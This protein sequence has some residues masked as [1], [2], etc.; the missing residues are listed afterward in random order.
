MA[1]A[2][3]REW[4]FVLAATLRVTGDIDVAE[5]C[6]QDA[7]GRALAAWTR[8]GIPARP[9][10]WLTTVA[11]RRAIDVLR[12]AASRARAQRLAEVA[13]DVVE[14]QLHDDRLQL[15]FVCCHPALSVETQVALALR[16]LCGLTTAEVA[17]AFLVSESTMAARLTR[18]KR[19]IRDARI[20][21]RVPSEV[22]LPARLDAVLSAIHL[23]FTTG[24]T[25]PSGSTLVRRD[26]VESA[27]Q[28]AT[29]LHELLPDEPG[30]TGLL[31]LIVLTDARRGARVRDDG[32]L[33]LL[34]EQDRSRWDVA[35]LGEGRALVRSALPGAASN[36]F[37]LMAAIAA[38]HGEASS[39]EATDWREIVGLY[40]LLMRTWPSPVVALNRAVALSFADGPA[41]G[42]AALETLTDEPHLA[43]YGYLASARGDFLRRMGE[44]DAA[45]DAYRVA[46]AQQSNEVERSFLRRRLRE[47]EV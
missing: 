2:Y 29:M 28:L 37:V 41:S 44:R 21:Y 6:V 23:V 12:H 31:A 40:D 19:K 18:G 5:E 35:A 10:A 47:L 33:A 26:L 1:D 13:Q 17:R 16:L 14:E 42:L 32:T 9:G 46:L 34:S 43:T 22:D 11:R 25:A 45:R 20:P 7:F 39:W 8:N 27:K 38:V 4:G 24:H 30:V 15:I 3:R 36:R